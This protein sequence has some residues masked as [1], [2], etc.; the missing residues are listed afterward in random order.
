VFYTW[1][2]APRR[3]G[4]GT[5]AGGLEGALGEIKRG[6]PTSGWAQVAEALDMKM[7]V[8]DPAGGRHAWAVGPTVGAGLRRDGPDG[9]GAGIRLALVRRSLLYRD[10]GATNPS[11]SRGF[12][13][14]W[15][16]CRAGGGH[17]TRRAGPAGEMQGYRNPGPLADADTSTRSRQGG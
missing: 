11:R 16:L 1:G 17:Q 3:N 7:G 4:R 9:R 13:E 6:L 15:S 5:R 10:W 14:C 12:W 8:G 2:T